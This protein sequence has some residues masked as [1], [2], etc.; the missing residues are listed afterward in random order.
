MN[1]FKVVTI[2][3]IV[4]RT[5]TV[6]VMRK[7]LKLQQITLIGR[8]TFRETGNL[9]IMRRNMKLL[10]LRRG[11]LLRRDGYDDIWTHSFLL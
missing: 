8:P 7:Y 6:V 1:F 11:E 9:E 2:L 3:L 5:L 10:R 4:T